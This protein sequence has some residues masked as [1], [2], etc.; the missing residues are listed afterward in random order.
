MEVIALRDIHSGEEILNSYLD[1]STEFTSEERR[2]KVR[3][4]WNFTCT[5]PICVGDG[6]TESDERRR[7]ITKAKDQIEAAGHSAAG[8]LTQVKTLLKLYEEEE[9]IMPRA[10]NYWLAAVAANA[11]GLEK[12]AVGFAGLARKYWTIMFGEDSLLVKDVK[13][14][15]WNPA[16]HP[17]RQRG[18]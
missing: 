7:Q 16:R 11:L 6:V 9:M 10:Q 5:C 8:V 1:A 13:E 14:L 18:A 12:Q 3:D 4:E 17:S 2:R 15:E